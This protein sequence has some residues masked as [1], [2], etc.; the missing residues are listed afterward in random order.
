MT[1]QYLMFYFVIYSVAGWLIE[2]IYRSIY[3]KKIINSG[4]LHAPCCPI[5]GFG[6]I[7]MLLLLKNVKNPALLFIM[8]FTILSVWEYIVGVILEKIFHTK[9]W[10]YS[11]YKLNINGRVCLI[12]SIY[13]GILTLI[14]MHIIHPFVSSIVHKIPV[15]IICYI[16]IIAY[17]A[18]IIDT[19]VSSLKIKAINKKIEELKS[20]STIIK[21]KVEKLKEEAKNKSSLKMDIYK[22]ELNELKI[23]HN[24]ISLKLYKQVLRLK[25][26]FPNM[27]SETINKYFNNK[28]ELDDIKKK[29]K[30]IKIS[31]N[32]NTDKIK[33]KLGRN[34]KCK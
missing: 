31:I 23:K 25:Q 20:L 15:E 6:A 12:N 19:I 16:N 11:N 1:I 27:N 5:Y 26:A 7:I 30:E 24:E 10:D 2:S 28:I 33:N 8:G 13:W 18:I 34:N 3:D 22:T 4:F 14:F 17:I 32:K 9:Y 29:I 21:N